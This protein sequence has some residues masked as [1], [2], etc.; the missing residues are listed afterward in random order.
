MQKKFGR[1]FEDFK[2]GDIYKHWPGKTIF[3]SDSNLFCL[4]TMNRHPVHSDVNYCKDQKYGKIL[5]CG[6]LTV[7]VVVGMT[8]S[9][10]SGKAIANLGYEKIDHAG[11]VFIGDTLYATTKVLRK[12]ASKSAPDRGVVYLETRGYNQN[13]QL[14]LILRRHMLVPKKGGAK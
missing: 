11:P 6:L 10:T 13:D 3:E 7:S 5:V 9:D 14:V 12:R 4:L 2:V 1:C 8:V